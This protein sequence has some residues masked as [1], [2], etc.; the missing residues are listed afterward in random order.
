MGLSIALER[1]TQLSLQ[2]DLSML[3]SD[4]DTC[5]LSV[6]ADLGAELSHVT[7]IEI[8]EDLAQARLDGAY[9]L[10]NYLARRLNVENG[11]DFEMVGED[12]RIILDD[13]NLAFADEV[14]AFD[15]FPPKFGYDPTNT[16]DVNAY[17]RH[18]EQV[19]VIFTDTLAWEKSKDEKLASAGKR[20]FSTYYVYRPWW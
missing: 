12:L 3:G 7:T 19:R 2:D 9:P 8:T 18:L 17:W 16:N 11:Q 20:P 5:F 4:S 13:L 14:K 6:F 1:R 15:I 10:Q